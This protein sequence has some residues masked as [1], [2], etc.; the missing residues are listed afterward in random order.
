M[1]RPSAYTEELGIEICA[2]IAE[3]KTL[4]QVAAEE[5]MPSVRTMLGWVHEHPE[6]DRRY[7]V[8]QKEKADLLL[9]EARTALDEPCET[10]V[11]VGRQ[12]NRAEYLLRM[13]AMLN[14]SKYSQRLGLGAAPEL[15]SLEQPMSPAELAR[16]I[17][18]IL[19]KA[20]VDK[21]PPPPPAPLQLVHVV[22]SPE[23][24][25][26]EA[27]RK[28]A[29]IT[30]EEVRELFKQ[31]RNQRPEYHGS[32]AEQGLATTDMPTTY[33]TRSTLTGPR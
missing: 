10:N 5:G 20:A 2:R 23:E 30:D 22:R 3:G 17:A 13:A 8:A 15:P 18:F 1:P 14:P 26:R 28:V 29:T 9:D 24:K 12:R 32:A 33:S 27:A 11:D 19:Q 4:K 7:N 6:F 21:D 31:Q 25:N 16:H